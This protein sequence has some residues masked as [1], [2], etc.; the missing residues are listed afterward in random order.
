MK[1][2]YLIN[3]YVG[4]SLIPMQSCDASLLL[5]TVRRGVVSEQTSERSFGMR[6]FKYVNTIKEAVEQ[7]CPLTV[8]CADIVALSARDGIVMVCHIYIHAR[9]NFGT[10]ITTLTF[11]F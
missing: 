6:N 8:S 3:I 1:L 7:E 2:Y 5:G 11:L 9:F 4:F 10:A